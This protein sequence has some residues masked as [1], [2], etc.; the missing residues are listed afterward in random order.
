MST[1]F[2]RFAAVL[3]VLSMVLSL[4]ACKKNDKTEAELALE[5]DAVS[6]G[7]H[8]LS[9]VMLNYFF[10]DAVT[11]WYSGYGASLGLDAST[12]LNEQ[13]INAE[14]GKTWADSFMEMALDNIRSTYALY[15]LAMANNFTL[16]KEEMLALDSTVKELDS[17]IAYYVKLYSDMGIE[18]PYTNAAEYLEAVYGA[19]AT[20]EN[21]MEY[22]RIC[23]YAD[24]YYTAYGDALDYTSLQLQEY[25]KEQP[26][27]YNSYSFTVYY[28]NASDFG[29]AES[30]KTAADQLSAGSYADKAAFDEAIKALSINTGKE[31]PVLSSAYTYVLY[32]NITDDYVDWLADAARVPGEMGVIAKE[33]TSGDTTTVKG[34]YVVRFDGMNDNREFMKTVR[35][36]LLAYEG[37]VLDTTTGKMNYSDKEKVEVKLEAEKLLMEYRTGAMTELQFS[38]L[39]DK[40]TDETDAPEG[41]LYTNVYRGKLDPAVE[42]W[43]FDPTR[44]PGDTTLVEGETGWHL[45]Y[46]VGNSEIT[47]R[48]Q[49][50]T[51]DLRIED[52]SAWYEA[53]MENMTITLLDDSFVNKG[54]VLNNL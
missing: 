52:V 46:F 47:F 29:S 45:I 4:A 36:I 23:T 16:P 7:S 3:L 14:S 35:H 20:T 5:T 2:K 40:H 6:V 50:I 51:N 37:G 19:G 17:M 22:C 1:I 10:M 53:L 18:Y 38:S 41:G 21:Y 30:A 15:D 49:M 28:L 44:N 12:P 34:Y 43:C 27:R 42:P 32:P 54:L 9:A 31:K 26:Q 8:T 25:E 33:S 11:D 13:V 48:D 39:A 24:A